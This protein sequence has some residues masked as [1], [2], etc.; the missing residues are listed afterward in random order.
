[1]GHVGVFVIFRLVHPIILLL[2]GLV[3]AGTL[4]FTTGAGLFVSAYAR[5]TAAAMATS[6]TLVL[7]VLGVPLVVGEMSPYESYRITPAS[8]EGWLH[9][10]CQIHMVTHG[11]A[12]MPGLSA[13]RPRHSKH[14]EEYIGGHRGTGRSIAISVSSLMTPP[15]GYIGGNPLPLGKEPL[16]FVWAHPAGERGWLATTALVGLTSA[17]WVLAGVGLGALAARRLRKGA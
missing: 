4:V 3:V 17:A 5:R 6:F 16:S 14:V 13:W 2:M 11:A 9:P 12:D 15:D 10:L 1:M 8:V 7:L